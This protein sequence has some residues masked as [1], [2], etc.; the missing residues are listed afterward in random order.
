L[1][2]VADTLELF[3]LFYSISLVA[4]PAGRVGL[5]SLPVPGIPFLF[6]CVILSVQQGRGCR[7]LRYSVSFIVLFLVSEGQIGVVL[8]KAPT[9]GI[10]KGAGLEGDVLRVV[11]AAVIAKVFLYVLRVECEDYFAGF[12]GTVLQTTLDPPRDRRG[13]VFQ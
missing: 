6:R 10:G 7:E 12:I 13:H 9:E 2:P 1:C 3:L 5:L 11:A 4:V 8:S